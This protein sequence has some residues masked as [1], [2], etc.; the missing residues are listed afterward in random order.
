VTSRWRAEQVQY[1]AAAGAV[2][3]EVPAHVF[4]H[5]GRMGAVRCAHPQSSRLGEGL[6]EHSDAFSLRE[7]I[8]GFLQPI[9]SVPQHRRAGPADHL[10]VADRPPPRVGRG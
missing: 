6:V 8:L 7:R 3:C 5:A 9:V 1:P 2:V 10:P 4:R